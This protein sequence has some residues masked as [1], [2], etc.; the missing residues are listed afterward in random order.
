M[1]VQ[2]R[3]VLVAKKAKEQLQILLNH[4]KE[5]ENSQYLKDDFIHFLNGFPVFIS[6]NG[7]IQAMSF[8]KDKEGHLYDSFKNYFG[9]DVLN[10]L[11]GLRDIN[12]YRI[13]QEQAIEFAVWLKRL[14][15]SLYKNP[16][17]KKQSE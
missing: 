3:E 6:Q 5:K 12:K 11:I 8:V 13:F 2:K 10:T 17:P 4:Y 15:N 1:A 14:A 16:K 9:T 7:L